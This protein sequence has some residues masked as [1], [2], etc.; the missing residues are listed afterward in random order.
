MYM[1]GNGVQIF[2]I[3]VTFGGGEAN[4]AEVGSDSCCIT[5]GCAIYLK[6]VDATAHP[7]PPRPLLAL[8]VA[9]LQRRRP[10]AR[11]LPCDACNRV[12]T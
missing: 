2:S 12:I 1:S 11:G 10:C 3:M 5:F 4:P 7:H 6:F 9:T 8:M